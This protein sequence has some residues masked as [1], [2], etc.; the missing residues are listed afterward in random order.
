M[1][2]YYKDGES[3]NVNIIS[4]SG[5]A[6][7]AK[8]TLF[9]TS[10]RDE[11][12]KSMASI[13]VEKDDSVHFTMDGNPFFGGSQKVETKSE[14]VRLANSN[15]FRFNEDDVN[16][17]LIEDR[18]KAKLPFKVDPVIKKE[19]IGKVMPAGMTYACGELLR[20]ANDAFGH[21]IQDDITIKDFSKLISEHS[22]DTKAQFLAKELSRIES[23]TLVVFSG[24]HRDSNKIDYKYTVIGSNLDDAENL[25]DQIH[26]N[27]IEKKKYADSTP[28]RS[29]VFTGAG[30]ELKT[31]IITK[32]PK[33]KNKNKLK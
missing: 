18:R 33:V 16:E 15:G 32:E 3:G 23:L 8:E 13:H 19:S 28:R 29:S 25:V 7:L 20:H 11:H 10:S 14:A 2:N 31:G 5:S 21:L 27:E 1:K 30:G 6:E 12:Q 24:N 9:A 22:I 26:D 4:D 17:F